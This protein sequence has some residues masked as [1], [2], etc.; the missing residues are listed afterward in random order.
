MANFLVILPQVDRAAEGASRMR[1]GIKLARA[2][3]GQSPNSTVMT[4]WAYAAFFPRKNSSGTPIATDPA[5]GSWLISI[6]TWFHDGGYGSGAETRLLARYLEIG[7]NALAR[8]LDG[9]FCVVVGDGRT[10]EVFAITDIAGSC[11]AFLRRLPDGM[12]LSSSSLLL[13]AL[14][15]TRLDPV[16]CQEFLYSGVI[17]EDR[18][19][20]REVRKLGPASVYRF[21]DGTVQTTNSHWDVAMLAPRTL[22][23][24]AAVVGMWEALTDAAQRIGRLFPR[25]SCD[26]TAGYDSRALVAAFVGAGVPLTTTVAGP[27]DSAD[28]R[29]S[30]GL[31][32]NIGLTHV[33]THST[34]AISVEELCDALALTDGEY[35]LIDYVRIQRTHRTLMQQFDVTINGSYGGLARAYCWELLYPRIGA[36]VPLNAMKLARLRYCA[37]PYDPSLAPH[38]ASPD[39]VKHVAEAIERTCAGLG[40]APNTLQMDYANMRMRIQR[41]QG[42]IASSTNQ[43]WPCLSPFMMRRPLETMLQVRVGLRLRSLLIRRMLATFQPR[44]ANYPLEHGYP[45]LPASWRTLHRFLPVFG[46]YGGRAWRKLWK[47]S[48]AAAATVA[49]EQPARLQLWEEEAICNL[50]DPDE[51]QLNTLIETRALADFLQRS[52]SELFAF[53]GQWRRLLSLELMLSRLRE[54]RCSI[55]T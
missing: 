40:S 33:R 41:W 54:M 15:P 44:I 10:R 51:M 39:F 55:T 48:V 23:D 42:R 24:D 2:L 49:R 28:V 7:A 14:G 53:D 13:A 12:A 19:A 45:A 46:Y 3:K 29:I 32:A 21:V 43:L 31:A 5:T 11:H 37:T 50:L 27:P 34:D 8:E 6:G 4:P 22:D 47:K 1:S 17:Y 18:T 26:L 52:R 20:F 36:H 16:G 30:T 38:G 9:F 35:D 25:V